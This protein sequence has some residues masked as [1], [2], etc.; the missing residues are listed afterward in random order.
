MFSDYPA[1]AQE[2]PKVDAY[3]PDP[4]TIVADDPD[5]VLVIYDADGIVAILDD[6]DIPVLYLEAPHDL[7]GLFDQIR[8][9]GEVTGN[10]DSAEDV[11]SAL[12]QRVQAIVEELEDVDEGPR[13][14]HELDESLY[15]VSPDSFIGDLYNL[16]KAQNIAD[17]ALGDYPQ[18]SEEAIL[19]AD[20][21][22]II[23]PTHGV[24]DGSIA[25]G[26]RARAGWGSIDAVQNDR[27]YEIDGDIV[28]RPGPRIVD[29]L[30]QL[31]E[32]IYPERFVSQNESVVAGDDF[33]VAA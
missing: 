13:I 33:R 17:A 10:R 28:S 11:A 7:Q 20:P 18:L 24:Q 4:E 26:V 16:L 32:M 29:A 25:D 2:L 8:M 23:V 15:T 21:E 3:Q 6:L 1:E 27:I 19:D 30:E 31:A 22:V 5:L 9:L 14:Y 12:E